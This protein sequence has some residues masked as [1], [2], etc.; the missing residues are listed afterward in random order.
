MR[1][2]IKTPEDVKFSKRIRYSSGKY[3]RSVNPKNYLVSMYSDNE[4]TVSFHPR[5][6][7]MERVLAPAHESKVS[8][9]DIRRAIFEHHIN[10]LPAPLAEDSVI[11]ELVEAV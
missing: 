8:V 10:W 2:K 1:R 5:N 6:R 9:S 3:V 7:P 4:V 11:E